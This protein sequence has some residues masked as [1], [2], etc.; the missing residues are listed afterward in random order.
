[1]TQAQG[2]YSQGYNY[3]ASQATSPA[4]RTQTPVDNANLI[5][6]VISQI[7]AKTG[8]NDTNNVTPGSI[9]PEAD[10]T[11]RTAEAALDGG[12]PPSYTLPGSA[13][14]F[15]EDARTHTL[16]KQRLDE[17]PPEV[18]AMYRQQSSELLYRYNAREQ[19]AIQEVVLHVIEQEHSEEEATDLIGKL[20]DGRTEW[21]A[22]RIAR[23][24]MTRLYNLGLVQ[25]YKDAPDLWGYE[26]DVT[27]DDRTTEICKPLAGLQFRK[28]QLTPEKM[29]PL[30]IS[31]RTVLR[32][33][34]NS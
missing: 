12:E 15:P 34:V 27:L 13:S 7:K 30:H 18:E 4:N 32:I 11:Q 23:T 9:A 16:P 21:Q 31:C 3:G 22:R 26:Y 1:M 2:A 33:V 6:S 28:D 8:S 19:D 24:E 14:P 20:I 5:Q 25:A 29:P 17:L 10:E